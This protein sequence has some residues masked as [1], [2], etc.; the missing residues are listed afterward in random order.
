LEFTLQKYDLVGNLVEMKECSSSNGVVTVWATNL[1]TFDG[2]NRTATEPFKDGGKTRK[3]G[4]QK[5]RLRQPSDFLIW[6]NI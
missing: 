1:W 2:L 5:A 3:A 4:A 6:K